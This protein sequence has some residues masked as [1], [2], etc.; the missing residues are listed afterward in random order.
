VQGVAAAVLVPASLALIGAAYD[1]R[2]RGRAIGVWSA[3]V[4]LGG[5][6]G[7]ILGGF[8][9]QEFSWR[10]VFFI[11]IPISAAAVVLALL[12]VAES[13]DESVRG[14]PLD[15]LGAT[16]MTAGMAAIVFALI[17]VQSL[18]AN[19]PV[20]LLV[21]AAGIIALVVFFIFER[22]VRS[23]IVP[24]SLFKL[25]TF[26]RVNLMTILLYAALGGAT[27]F[28]PFELIQ[29]RHYSPAGSGAA[30]A[31]LV[32]LITLGSRWAGGLVQRY[33]ARVPLVVGPATVAVGFFL[34]SAL[35]DSQSYWASVFPAIVVMGLGLTIT[36]APITTVAMDSVPSE[37][38]GLASGVNNAAARLAGLVAVALFGIVMFADFSHRLDARLASASVSPRVAVQI[39]QQRDRLAGIVIPSNVTPAERS[40][41]SRVIAGAFDDA[42]RLAMLIAAALAGLA[43]IVGASLPGLATAGKRVAP[44]YISARP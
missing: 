13:R 30:L 7:P 41:L 1:E 5:A 19:V 8:L 35:R 2:E 3:V 29:V 39:D 26:V 40:T 34:F 25:T 4:A 36:V 28:I 37:H 24:L 18:G 38:V 33:G 20:L 14:Q 27:Y 15:W 10:L 43:A 9:T 12:R 44:A 31:P 6:V 32:V 22:H 11:N 16:I 21:L 23:P 42:F 17:Q